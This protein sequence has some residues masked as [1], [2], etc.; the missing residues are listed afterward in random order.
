MLSR[1]IGKEDNSNAKVGRLKEFQVD[2]TGFLAKQDM[3]LGEGD[4]NDDDGDS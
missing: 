4:D 3:L 2:P 1:I